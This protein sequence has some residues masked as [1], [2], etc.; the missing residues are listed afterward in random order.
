MNI[1]SPL[2]QKVMKAFLCQ[3]FNFLLEPM[4]LMLDNDYIYKIKEVKEIVAKDSILALDQ[5]I[6]KCQDDE[7]FNDC[8]TRNYMNAMT[9]NCQ[10]LPFHLKLRAKV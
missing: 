5:D 2:K 1:L 6:R 8:V 10:C 7:V 4:K 3:V 9:S